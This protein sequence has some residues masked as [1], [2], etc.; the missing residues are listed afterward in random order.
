M[1]KAYVTPEL[2]KFAVRPDEQFAVSCLWVNNYGDAG[3]PDKPAGYGDCWWDGSDGGNYPG[4][5]Y[6]VAVHGS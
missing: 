4:D 1:M 5:E 2:E 6:L 3:T